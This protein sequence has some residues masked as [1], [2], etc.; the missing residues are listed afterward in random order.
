[1]P[2]D[3]FRAVVAR[4]SSGRSR[5]PP[6]VLFSLAAHGVVVLCLVLAAG[7]APDGLPLPHVALA[8]HAAMPVRLADIELPVPPPRKK[9]APRSTGEA[10]NVGAPEPAPSS[11]PR[12]A[13]PLDAPTG[14]TPETG[15]EHLPTSLD[16][17]ASGDSVRPVAPGN[18]DIVV[19]APLVPTVAPPVRLHSGITAPRKVVDVAPS[20]PPVARIAHVE[21]VVVLEATIDRGG[22][23]TDLRVLRS[24]PLLDDA[25]L[26]AVRQ[27]RFTPGQLNGQDVAVIITVTVRFALDR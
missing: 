10:P 26:Q 21:G 22:R 8:Y 25:A 15:N 14:V 12:P 5:R 23:V 11:P 1:M 19:P 4:P 17:A 7:T 13:A 3:L 16:H 9:P 27:W 24:V 2:H 6:L 20:Y 18:A